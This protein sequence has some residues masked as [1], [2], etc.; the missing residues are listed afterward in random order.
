MNNP[1]TGAVLY[2]PWG[3]PSKRSRQVTFTESRLQYR[4][5]HVYP[6][7]RSLL[8]SSGHR[9]GPGPIPG[10][11][12]GVYGVQSGQDTRFTLEAL[13]FTKFRSFHLPRVLHTRS[14][15]QGR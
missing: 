7:T 3:T 10:Q 14:N 11:P 1:F 5:K 2:T 15:H 8:Q 4:I 6:H 13:V 9:G 12:C